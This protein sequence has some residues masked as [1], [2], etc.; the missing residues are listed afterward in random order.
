MGGDLRGVPSAPL[1]LE[2]WGRNNAKAP[3]LSN[4]EGCAAKGVAR[5]E[6]WAA[7]AYLDYCSVFYTALNTRHAF[8]P[9]KPNEFFSTARTL[10]TLRASFGT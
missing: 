10:P 6:N 7:S 2:G 8:W 4:A 5:I 3:V 1:L 9:P